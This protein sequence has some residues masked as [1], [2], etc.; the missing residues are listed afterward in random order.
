MTIEEYM[1]FYGGFFSLIIAFISLLVKYI[2]I[3][4]YNVTIA[5]NIFDYE[6]KKYKFK[7]K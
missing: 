5:N 1:S 6:H 2:N 4:T 7:F 3:F